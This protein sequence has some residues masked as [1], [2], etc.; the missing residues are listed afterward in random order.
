[1]WVKK[2][3]VKIRGV[4]NRGGGGKVRETLGTERARLGTARTRLEG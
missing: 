3:G 4:K 2:V 1:M